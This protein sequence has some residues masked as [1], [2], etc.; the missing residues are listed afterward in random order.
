MHTS[1]IPDR[2]DDYQ[3]ELRERA[4]FKTTV[5]PAKAGI[6]TLTEVRSTLPGKPLKNPFPVSGRSAPEKKS[7]RNCLTF[8]SKSCIFICLLCMTYKFIVPFNTLLLSLQRY[9]IFLVL[10]NT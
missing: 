7:Y 8:F 1:V 2:N 6:L 5:I 4:F 9:I 10:C 3:S